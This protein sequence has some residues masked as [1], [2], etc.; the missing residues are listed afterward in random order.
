[1]D[2]TRCSTLKTN[3]LHSLS[4]R[5]RSSI[6]SAKTRSGA[7]CGSD[8]ELLIAKFSLKLKKVE[9]TT[10]PFRYDLNQIPYDY[11]VEVRNIFKGLDLIDRV[12]PQHHLIKGWS[13]YGAQ[14][15][16]SAG[17]PG[18]LGP[19]PWSG[20]GRRGPGHGELA[21]GK[22]EWSRTLGPES[23]GAVNLVFCYIISPCH[24]LPST[25]GLLTLKATHCL[26]L[27]TFSHALLSA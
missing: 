3:C 27:R 7:V 8:H 1:M 5:W 9:K 4:Q 19:S 20:E 12:S 23:M 22:G 14:K 15:I 16:R 24:L 17:C 18:T 6:Q 13:Q 10:R 2:I 26:C 11:T 25:T 21:C